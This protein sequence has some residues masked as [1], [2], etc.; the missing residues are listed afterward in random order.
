M[1]IEYLYPPN[2]R[3]SIPRPS[4]RRSVKA[5]PQIFRPPDRAGVL[6][7][8]V[9]ISSSAVIKVSGCELKSELA[10][11]SFFTPAF[12]RVH[13][14]LL[15]FLPSFAFLQRFSFRSTIGEVRLATSSLRYHR[16]GNRKALKVRGS[17]IE[18]KK[19][20]EGGRK[21]RKI[22]R[23]NDQFTFAWSAGQCPY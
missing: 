22:E 21:K 10:T 15:R 16:R 7:S 13:S 14:K 9:P 4:S 6:D 8:A 2:C 20:G 19:K 5:R 18:A 3:R 23:K 12:F 1:K 17:L 11:R